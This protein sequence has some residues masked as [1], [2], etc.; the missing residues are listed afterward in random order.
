M[1]KY[2]A[3]A[4]AARS[5]AAG[6][7]AGDYDQCFRNSLGAR[8]RAAGLSPVKAADQI[9]LC[10]ITLTHWE[11]GRYWPSSIWLPKLAAAYGCSIEELFIPP[12]GEDTR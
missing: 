5:I 10:R 11:Q 4:L 2:P 7:D 9:G 3:S 1:T 6:M 12:D 8:R